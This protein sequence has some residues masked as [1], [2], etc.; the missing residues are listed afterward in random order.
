MLLESCSEDYIAKNRKKM[1]FN[2]EA[3]SESCADEFGFQ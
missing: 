3:F 1:S 2:E